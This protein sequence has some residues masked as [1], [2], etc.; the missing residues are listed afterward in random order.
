MDWLDA[1]LG[2]TVADNSIFAELPRHY[3]AEYDEDMDALNVRSRTCHNYPLVRPRPHRVRY[4]A[5][6]CGKIKILHYLHSDALYVNTLTDN[7]GF[8]DMLR[9]VLPMCSVWT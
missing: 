5:A 9:S 8:H 6:Q 3:E 2:A 1:H 7:S 4:S